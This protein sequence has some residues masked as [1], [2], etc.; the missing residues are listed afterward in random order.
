MHSDTLLVSTKMGQWQ[1]QGSSPKAARKGGHWQHQ[2]KELPWLDSVTSSSGLTEC[3]SLTVILH[4]IPVILHSDTILQKRKVWRSTY[5]TDLHDPCVCSLRTHQTP[6]PI[7]IKCLRF[8]N[9]L[10]L[11]VKLSSIWLHV[12]QLT[13]KGISNHNPS[14]SDAIFRSDCPSWLQSQHNDP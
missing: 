6:N 11:P 2:I 4:I 12:C 3:G 13:H 10:C 1:H 5:Q 8:E 7:R 14:W 9:C